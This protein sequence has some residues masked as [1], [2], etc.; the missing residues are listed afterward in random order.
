M[1]SPSPSREYDVARLAPLDSLADDAENLVDHDTEVEQDLLLE[2]T[3]LDEPSP[4]FV[5]TSNEVSVGSIFASLSEARETCQKFAK[6]ALVQRSQKSCKFVRLC[7]FR[8]GYHSKVESKLPIE[9]QRQRKTNKCGCLF[10]VKLKALSEKEQFEVYDIQATHNHEVFDEM[11]L[12]QLPQNRFIPDNVKARMLELNGH[13]ILNCSQILTLIDT[14]FDVPV[15]WNRRDVQNLFQSQKNLKMETSEFVSL[16]NGKVA[17]GWKIGVQLDDET[18]RLERI[19]W[20]SKRGIDF[21]TNFHDVLEI[22]A[23]YKTNR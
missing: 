9:F 10:V 22:D 1:P 20:I 8:A 14:E 7:C 19:F 13:G 3:H 18:L 12:A 4:Y 6:C 2:T 23:T 5:C 16:L 11:E 21:Y 17:D 15:T